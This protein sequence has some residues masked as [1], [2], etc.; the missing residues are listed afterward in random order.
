MEDLFDQSI[1]IF[2]LDFF[3]FRDVLAYSKRMVNSFTR[4]D[5][6]IAFTDTC[7]LELYICT[8][9]MHTTTVLSDNMKHVLISF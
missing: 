7:I 3:G 2:G 8:L 1:P 4:H 9:M 5:F 6:M